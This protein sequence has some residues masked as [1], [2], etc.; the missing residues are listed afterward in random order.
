MGDIPLLFPFVAA[1]LG[2]AYT[3]AGRV[4]DA[5]PLLEQAVTQGAAMDLRAG[6]A[7]RLAWLG[8]ALLSTDELDR[9]GEQAVQA[10]ALAERLGERGSQAYARRLAGEI[11]MLREP[12][13]VQAAATAYRDA[14]RLATEL[15]MRPLVARCRLGLATVHRH[16][17]AEVEAR[18]DQ[19]AAVEAFRAMQMVHWLGRAETLG[20]VSR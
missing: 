7:L 16:A 12:P 1:P 14:L 18:T 2:E 8:E 20:V 17:G 5:V 9:A 19:D 10:L 15:K 3:L 4:S 11:A 6:H 13:D